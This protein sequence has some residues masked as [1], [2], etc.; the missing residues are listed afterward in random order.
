M[1]EDLNDTMGRL[2][3]KVFITEHM[4]E[5]GR[6][7]GRFRTVLSNSCTYEYA[8]QIIEDFKKHNPQLV[9]FNHVHAEFR[10]NKP[11]MISQ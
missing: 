5:H 6:E 2:L 11:L 4:D 8:D 1:N 10:L 9:K 7:R 3:I